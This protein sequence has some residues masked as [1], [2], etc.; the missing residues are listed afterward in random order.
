MIGDAVNIK[1]GFIVNIGVNFEIIVLPNYNN[2][3]VLIKCID[4]LKVYFAIDNW[5]I[6]QPIILR[7][8]YVL[9]SKI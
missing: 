8:L 4:A 7:D 3:E 2:N 5:S 1:D 6:N 9:L